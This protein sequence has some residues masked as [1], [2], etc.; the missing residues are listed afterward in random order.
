[1]HGAYSRTVAA[2]SRLLWE[3]AQYAM[4]WLESDVKRLQLRPEA[5]Q[6]ELSAFEYGGVAL[7]VVTVNVIQRPMRELHKLH[8]AVAIA[9]GQYPQVTFSL[10]VT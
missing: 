4:R 10:V 8:E 7:V 9:R 6:V 3:R 5:A 1:L 2:A